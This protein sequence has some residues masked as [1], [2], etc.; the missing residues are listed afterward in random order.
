MS[1]MFAQAAE[2]TYSPTQRFLEAY[3]QENRS[4]SNPEQMVFT[5]VEGDVYNPS[6]PFDYQGESYIMARYEKRENEFST[7]S[8]FFQ[9]QVTDGVTSWQ[10]GPDVSNLGLL[11]EGKITQD[12]SITFIDGKPVIT[13]VDVKLNDPRNPKLGCTYKSDFYTGDDLASLYLFAVG[14]PRMKGIRPLQLADGRV[15]VFT[16]PQSDR[17]ETGGAGKI[18]FTIFNTPQDIMMQALAEAPLIPDLFSN[19]EWGGVNYPQLLPN[20]PVG[21]LGHIAS[22]DRHNPVPDYRRYAPLYFEFDPHS[23]EVM[24]PKLLGTRHGLPPEYPSKRED[25]YEVLYPSFYS[26]VGGKMLVGVGVSDTIVATYET[27]NPL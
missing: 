21:V 16:R 11:T 13:V 19:D 7:K 27:E 3:H 24:N 18:G 10:Y 5:G 22:F 8:G 20:G 25:L 17:P 15:G 14:P 23:R 1:T 12:P 9:K 6:A 4:M 26:L 2:T